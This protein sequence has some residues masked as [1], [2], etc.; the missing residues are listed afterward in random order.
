MMDVNL[1]LYRI[2]CIVAQNGNISKAAEELFVSQ[3]AVSQTIKQLEKKLGGKLFNRSAR[4]VQLTP[5][6][7]VLFSYVNSA[8]SLV[9][10][11]EE[12][13]LRIQNLREGE[14]KIG[15]SD[16]ICS[17][18]LLPMLERFNTNY[19]DIHISVTNRTT[20]ESIDLLRNGTVDLSFVNLPIDNDPLLEITPVRPIRD[21]FVVGEK[22]AFLA[23]SVMR[24]SDLQS[25]P[26]LMLEIGRAHV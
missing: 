20:Q 23:D 12:K 19:P 13:L 6:G 9:K 3:S 26:I 1:E 18:F 5:E 15:A 22:Y 24:L 8:V 21:C 25:H 10:N 11:A 16:T 4:G 7:E 14:I 2:F 17:L